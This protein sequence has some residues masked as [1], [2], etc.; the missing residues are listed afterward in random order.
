MVSDK[1][2]DEV[3]DKLIGII[4]KSVKDNGGSIAVKVAWGSRGDHNEAKETAYINK[5][6]IGS[7]N[8][9][10]KSKRGIYVCQEYAYDSPIEEIRSI[11]TL[12]ELAYQCEE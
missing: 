12:F 9:L 6:T 8:Y 3:R 2:H 1:L 11:D 4:E 5:V 10:D 7:D